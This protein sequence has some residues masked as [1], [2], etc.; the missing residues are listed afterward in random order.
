MEN[1]ECD[2]NKGSDKR[3]GFY[4]AKDRDRD[5]AKGKDSHKNKG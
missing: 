5:R 1:G 2:K 4:M 3:K